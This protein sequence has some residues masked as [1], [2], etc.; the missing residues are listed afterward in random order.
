MPQRDLQVDGRRAA[1]ASL[2]D[3]DTL[4][5]AAPDGPLRDD[6]VGLRSQVRAQ[7]QRWRA[8]GR[9]EPRCDAWLLGYEPAFSALIAEQGWIG[10]TWSPAYGGAGRSYRERFVVT[11]ELLRAGVP[12]AAHWIGDRQIG[13]SIVTYGSERLKAELLPAIARAEARFC[14]GMSE[15]EAGSDLAAVRTRAERVPSGWRL[16]GQ[17]VWS[18]N[19]HRSNFAYVLARTSGQP[20]QHAGLSEFLLDMDQSSVEVRPIFDL[21]GQEHFCEIFLDGAF[22]PDGRILGEVGSGWQQVVEQLSFERGGPERLLSTY[23]LLALLVG[24]VADG[25]LRGRQAEIGRL[26]AT[27]APLRQMAWDL[28]TQM[29]ARRVNTAA[30]AT[31]KYLGTQFEVDVV[32]TARAA[33]GE[34]LL[35]DRDAP[36]RDMWRGALLASP[37]FS[38]RGGTSEVLAG[39]IA[40]NSEPGAP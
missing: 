33:A 5:E 19:A 3:I 32:E 38:I 37:G 24:R 40:R 15:P 20:G 16:H 34:L 17:K 10:M 2:G 30:A 7:V 9:F 31:L 14:L 18:S 36:L 23:P 27:L 1:P 29:D 6:A 12:A 39:L 26:V 8:E 11:E 21:R 28:A 25:R 22:V 4:D 13:P 35:G